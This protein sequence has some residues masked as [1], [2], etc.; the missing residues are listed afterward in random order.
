MQQFSKDWNSITI[1]PVNDRMRAIFEVDYLVVIV[2][3]SFRKGIYDT[4][5][6]HNCAPVRY[7]GPTNL[8]TF[9]GTGILVKIPSFLHR[10]ANDLNDPRTYDSRHL[11]HNHSTTDT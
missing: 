4:T 3:G 11:A 7:R 9:N 8:N 10:F 2:P 6:H 5:A 1:R